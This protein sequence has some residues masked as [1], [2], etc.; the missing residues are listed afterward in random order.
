MLQPLRTFTPST[1]WSDAG[2]IIE[3]EHIDVVSDFGHWMARHG[4]L[5]DY[6]RA[7]VSPL[8]AAMRTYL[9][10]EYG[11]EVPKL[12]AWAPDE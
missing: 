2:P 5:Q 4:K 6:S 1:N 10:W 11:G 7:D 3:R 12:A 8:A 9:I